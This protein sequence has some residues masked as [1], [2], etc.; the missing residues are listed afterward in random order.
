M[1]KTLA[2]LLIA[3]MLILTF[4]A[5]DKPCEEHVD[6]DGDL[7]C[8]VCE[9]KL[10][11][12]KDPTPPP[13]THEDEDG[14]YV[15]DLCGKDLP[16][17]ALTLTSALAAQ[18]KKANT[19]ELAFS[20]TLRE[21]DTEWVPSEQNEGEFVE[22]SY[23]Y[24]G[25]AN[26]SI[27][28]GRVDGE[29]RMQI[30][31]ESTYTQDGEA[32]VSEIL[33]YFIG[34]KVYE[35]DEESGAFW[36]EQLPLDVSITEALDKLFEGISL[37]A[38][39]EKQL[40]TALGEHIISTFNIQ[41]Q[42]GSFELDLLPILR[43]IKEYVASWDF[44]VTTLGDLLNDALQAYDEELTV[45]V[46]LTELERVSALTVAEARAELDAWLT[47]NHET[48]LQGLIDG[49]IADERNMLLLENLLTAALEDSLPA[50]GVEA[51]SVDDIL[52][53]VRGFNLDTLI[54]EQGLANVILFDLLAS[55]SDAE[56]PS[57][58]ED[59]FAEIEGLFALTLSEFEQIFEP[60]FSVVQMSFAE[61]TYTE[62]CFGLDL[63]FTGTF[64]LS[65]FVFEHKQTS[66]TLSPSY[67][68]DELF[69]SDF[70]SAH[71]TVSL[72]NLSDETP[73]IAP[74]P[75]LPHYYNMLDVPYHYYDETADG[76][77]S[78]V[79]LSYPDEGIVMDV[80]FFIDGQE[81]T[82]YVR[83]LPESVLCDTTITI[84]E[85]SLSVNGSSASFD[86]ETPV[87]ISV[88]IAN[89]E[90]TVVQPPVILN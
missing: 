24:T 17:N 7:L 15:C 78:L 40:K 39:E 54:A 29:Y 6:Q 9:E 42:S 55:S 87:I 83:G 36:I 73:E 22:E 59:A 86:P 44:E 30:S 23:A 46:L 20:F 10:E 16:N 45:E 62:Y 25:E 31:L 68:S 1:K 34:D 61:T 48:T 69:D 26:G 50:E 72:K 70:Q 75:D 18:L 32:E 88:D 67:L 71:L 27:L 37:T 3:A 35:Y 60:I 47:E 13:C 5:C 41:N 52:E 76:Y 57:A 38:E 81:A 58:P 33:V 14:N 2:F 51:P 53:Q 89:R 19:L 56:T 12:K 65:S 11:P 64:D 85:F 43:D 66:T 84:P 28:I 8:D 74:D 90:F 63:G 82:M 21:Q 49:F 80:T 79:I 77:G 4:S